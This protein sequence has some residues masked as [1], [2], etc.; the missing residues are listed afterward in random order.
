[1]NTA[2]SEIRQAYLNLKS[3]MEE[4]KRLAEIVNASVYTE[5]IEISVED[6]SPKSKTRWF[7]RKPQ[8]DSLK[9]NT[10]TKTVYYWDEKTQ[11]ALDSFV[12]K[13]PH[14]KYYDNNTGG[15]MVYYNLRIDI[16]YFYFVH[17]FETLPPKFNTQDSVLLYRLACMI[18][19]AFENLEIR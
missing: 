13:F 5:E 2:I 17:L 15:V 1:M 3:A 19:K 14:V 7:N 8:S 9:P 11:D 6:A 10:T 4:A 12:K 18:N 16:D